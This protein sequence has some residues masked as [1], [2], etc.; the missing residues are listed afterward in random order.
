LFQRVD[1]IDFFLLFFYFLIIYFHR[2]PGILRIVKAA[3]GMFS[4]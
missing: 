2:F 3:L 1:W 4:L